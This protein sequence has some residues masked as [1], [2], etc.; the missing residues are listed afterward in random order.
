MREPT[1]G[2]ALEVCGLLEDGGLTALLDLAAANRVE[3]LLHRQLE[4]TPYR[5]HARVAALAGVREAQLQRHLRALTDLVAFGEVMDRLGAP[6]LVVKGPVL[7]ERLYS[8]PDLRLYGDL[9]L[10]VPNTVF[11]RTLEALEAEGVE[12]LD[13]NW[14]LLRR[15]VRGQVHLVLPYGSVAD[16]HW[17]LVNDGRIRRELSIDM[18]EVFA[19]RRYVDVNGLSVPTL[20]TSDM[21]AHLCLHAAL[22]GGHRLSWLQDLDRLAALEEPGWGQ[23]CTR[24]TEWGVGP[25]VGIV[26]A[27]CR[28]VLGTPV[29]DEVLTALFASIYRQHITRFVD[30]HSPPAFSGGRATPAT[31]WAQV[32]RPTWRATWR[33][34]AARLTRR[35]RAA[36]GRRRETGRLGAPGRDA[37]RRAAVLRVSGGPEDRA[38]Y[39]SEVTLGA[40]SQGHNTTE[41][42]RSA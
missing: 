1:A 25:L 17:H 14:T 21:V 9:D 11:A 20:D 29:P 8:R 28:S 33:A 26:L 27:R 3:A 35:S 31:V 42:R 18:S 38:E 41:P 30:H 5:S 4:L 22:A 12:V 7:A 36:L 2:P 40:R 32:A 39:L 15:E 6:W 13:R 19:A 16:L 10:V 24:A 37:P 23:V 34:T